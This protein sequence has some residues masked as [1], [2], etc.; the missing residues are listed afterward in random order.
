MYEKI[1]SFT[2]FG[3]VMDEATVSKLFVVYLIALGERGEG[4]KK[5]KQKPRRYSLPSE[6]SGSGL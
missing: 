2:L 5:T 6:L 4:E 1:A 3:I